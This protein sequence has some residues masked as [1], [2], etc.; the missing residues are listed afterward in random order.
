VTEPG[1]AAGGAE[2]RTRR[3]FDAVSRELPEARLSLLSGSPRAPWAPARMRA[4][5]RRVPPRLSRLDSPDTAE[6]LRKVVEGPGLTVA[7][8]T[9]TASLVDRSMLGKVVL[10]AHNIE[11][12]VNRQLA[13]SA[14]GTM[15]RVAYSLTNDW[16]ER[17]ET[18]LARSVAGVWAVSEAEADWFTGIGAR[19]WVVPNGVELPATTEPV[20][21]SHRILFVG[22]L[23]SVF[24]RRGL[25]WLFARVWPLLQVAVPDVSLSI[26]GAGP[27]L[28]VP[29]GVE[30]LGFVED[31]EPLYRQAQLCVAPL[32]SGAG[33]RLKVLEAMAN[34]RPVVATEVGADGLPLTDDDGV[35]KRDGG[36][37][38]ADACRQLLLEPETARELG[39]RARSK[40]VEFT[41]ER[42]ASVAVKSL[43]DLRRS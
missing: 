34:G 4:A 1:F 35:L 36:D 27:N 8:T 13:G 3:L 31:L 28:D 6:A 17:F 24:N 40:A 38:F 15:R 14:T 11:W 32:L 2:I 22:S 23:N 29:L 12:R 7:S 5:A 39:K 30:Q 33:T 21:E 19:V 26:A 10:D 41:W 9:F 25:E 16:M 20:A 18:R 42:V 43:A 37:E